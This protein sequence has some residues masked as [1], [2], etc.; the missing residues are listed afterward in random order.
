MQVLAPAALNFFISFAD[1]AVE[2]LWSIDQY[3]EFILLLM[4]STG[5]AFQVPVVQIML[6]QLRIVTA[7][8]MFRQWR[9]VVVGATIAAAG[10]GG[11]PRVPAVLGA[12]HL[13]LSLRSADLR[14][15]CVWPSSAW[16]A[17]CRLRQAQILAQLCVRDCC[18]YTPHLP[19]LHVPLISHSPLSPLGLVSS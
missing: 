1:G 3:F 5:L 4:L 6:G 17:P 7:D 19:Y 16:V 10:E 9:F 18:A 11:R 12:A 14:S 2:S 15:K 13:A 8:Q